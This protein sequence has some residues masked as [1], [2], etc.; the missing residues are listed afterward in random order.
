MTT[1]A[2]VSALGCER[3]PRRC[4]VDLEPARRLLQVPPTAD[5][6]LEHAQSALRGGTAIHGRVFGCRNPFWAAIGGK[7][8]SRA[9]PKA[10]TA[11]RS[12]QF[13][14]QTA[15]FGALHVQIVLPW[16]RQVAIERFFR[17]PGDR[18]ELRGNDRPKQPVRCP[19]GRI[20][21]SGSAGPGTAGSRRACRRRS[22]PWC[23]LCRRLRP[24]RAI[25]PPPPPRPSGPPVA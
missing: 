16:P 25:R 13:W 10:G 18:D 3:A 7:N 9:R 17:Q 8:R 11:P 20:R 5:G 24:S 19:R 21:C 12:A 14:R 23:R 6:A 4:L 22:Q 2:G 15:A 1:P